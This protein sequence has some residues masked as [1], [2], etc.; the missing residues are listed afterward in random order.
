[1]ILIFFILIKNKY[2]CVQYMGPTLLSLH[3]FIYCEGGQL[4]RH[5][6]PFGWLLEVFHKVARYHTCPK[7]LFE[8]LD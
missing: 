7:G 5:L 1:M 8:I 6:R 2:V 3:L 4:V